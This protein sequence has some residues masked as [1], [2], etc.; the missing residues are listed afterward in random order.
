MPDE[1]LLQDR[2]D[3]PVLRVGTTV[4]HRPHAWSPAVQ[5]L[6]GH[7]ASVDFAY[8]PRFLGIDSEG[9]EILQYLPGASGADG[10][11]PIVDER[12]LAAAARL[13]RDYH[14]A[15]AGFRLPAGLA[16]A[17]GC[18]DPGAGAIACH[19]DFGPWNLVWDGVRPV[20][21]LDWEY[22]FLGRPIDD[23]G[24]ALQYAVPFCDDAQA[25]RWQRFAAPPDRRARVE[26]FATAYGL[27]SLDGLVDAVIAAQRRT[28]ARVRALAAIGFERQLQWVRSGAI[29]QDEEAVR[30]TE[31]HRH[32]AE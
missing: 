18:S 14:A 28:I 21:L 30:W 1:E 29:E 6:L 13:L 8:A 2:A 25:M 19:G 15:V 26:I 3:R 23:I 22:A 32:L 9:R 12:G 27:T 7:L 5:A 11:A 4:R 17:P 24:Y 16:F 10:W 31:T 20:G